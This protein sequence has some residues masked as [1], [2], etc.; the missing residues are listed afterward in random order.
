MDLIVFG[1]M[2]TTREQIIL[3]DREFLLDCPTFADDEARPPHFLTL[4]P[5][6]KMLAK[7]ILADDLPLGTVCLEVG[8][9]LGLAGLAVLAKGGHV[10]F[11]DASPEATELACHNARL[12]GF[13]DCEAAPFDWR[14]PDSRPQTPL[15]IGSDITY[16]QESHD[17]LFRLLNS[18]LMPSGFA[19][20]ADCDR[21][22]SPPFF[23]LLRSN[24]W[25]YTRRV[26]HG[27]TAEHG[28]VRGTVYR[29]THPSHTPS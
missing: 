22:Q 10:I 7:A 16:Y 13:F 2:P 28:R 21:K 27:G 17:A 14:R 19:L 6:A 11:N 24:G 26:M 3:G 29:I 1:G 15:I 25:H 5:A 23:Q 9:G 18:S 12:N 8:C 20:I 4:W